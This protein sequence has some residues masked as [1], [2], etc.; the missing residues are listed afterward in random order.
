[1]RVRTKRVGEHAAA[2][3]STR[4]CLCA[5]KSLRIFLTS[6]GDLAGLEALAEHGGKE[7]ASCP[8]AL[9]P[10]VERFHMVAMAITRSS[11]G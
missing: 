2:I 3:P 1:M 4:R 6:R 7:L 8:Y 11:R 10:A 5:A 9:D